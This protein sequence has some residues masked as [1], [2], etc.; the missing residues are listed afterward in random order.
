MKRI[1]SIVILCLLVL[2]GCGSVNEENVPVESPQIATEEVPASVQTKEEKQEVVPEQE[3]SEETQKVQQPVEAEVEE[4]PVNDKETEEVVLT[5]PKTEQ[6]SKEVLQDVT[7][8]SLLVECADVL[9]NIETLKE[10]KRCFVPDDGV[11]F[12]NVN[13]EFSEGESVFDILKR[14]LTDGGVHLE[15]NLSPMFNNAY[16]EGIGNL[17]EFD[18]GQRS[19][20]KYSVNGEFPPVGCSDYKVKTGDKI[21]FSYKIKAY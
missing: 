12:S 15:F 13:V 16:I 2:G 11:M 18:C 6:E 3:K 8:V 9:D 19:G 7:T 17:Y 20:W 1:I 14:V 21:V 4:V 5:I 10:E